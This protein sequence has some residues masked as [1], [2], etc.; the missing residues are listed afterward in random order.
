MAT[1]KA[2]LVLDGER[3]VERA[4]HRLAVVADP[5]VVAPGRR[6]RLGPL[7]WPEVDDVDVDV[8]RGRGPLAGLAAALAASPVP[9]M[10]VVAVDLVDL[11]GALLAWLAQSWAGEDAVVP[12][13]ERGRP[14][15]L[16]AVYAAAASSALTAAV[17]R[18]TLAVHAALTEL[19]VRTV[20]AD[21]WRAA[22]F[23]PGWS[24]NVNRPEDLDGYGR[25]S[26]E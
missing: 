12:V 16:H 23:A 26:G 14:Q 15:P 24:R 20:D 1:D 2:A 13:D 11:D 6:G 21:E 3:L 19:D 18:G 5:V 9:L 22:S 4:A 8:D 10:A 25:S 17:R 7:P